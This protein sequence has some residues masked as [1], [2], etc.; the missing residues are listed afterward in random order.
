MRQAMESSAIAAVLSSY[1]AITP[2]SFAADPSIQGANDAAPSDAGRSKQHSVAVDSASLA[3]TLACT[4]I[5][6]V[7]SMVMPAS[8]T[9][10]SHYH[11]SRDGENDHGRRD[12]ENERRVRYTNTHQR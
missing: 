3:V 11:G 10:N 7:K 9:M 2:S 1:A 6:D 12:G 4:A 8:R 5:V